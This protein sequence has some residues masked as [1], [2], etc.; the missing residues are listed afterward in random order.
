MARGKRKGSR[1]TNRG[2]NRQSRGV[3]RKRASRRGGGGRQTIRLVIEQ[4]GVPQ[5]G[6]VVSPS[7]RRRRF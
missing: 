7:A 2:R 4:A 5:L 1:S 3:A 6:N